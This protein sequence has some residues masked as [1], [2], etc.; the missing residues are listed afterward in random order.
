V[1]NII[2]RMDTREPKKVEEIEANIKGALT[3]RAVAEKALEEKKLSAD[4]K[5]FVPSTNKG[6]RSHRRKSLKKKTSK[7]RKHHRRS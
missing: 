1:N 4:A 2:K 7:R 3:S 5:P 6:G